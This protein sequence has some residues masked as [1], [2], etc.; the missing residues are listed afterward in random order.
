[1]PESVHAKESKQL[2]WMRY[3]EATQELEIDFRGKTPSTYTY[4]G[5]PPE[6]WEAFKAAESKGSFFAAHVRFAKNPDGSLK[7]PYRKIR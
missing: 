5:F 7:Y 6:E 2:E 3:D 4:A 1:M